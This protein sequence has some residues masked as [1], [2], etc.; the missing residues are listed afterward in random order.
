ML[1]FYLSTTPDKI[2]RGKRVRGDTRE[3]EKFETTK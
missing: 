3:E 2:Y 1:L